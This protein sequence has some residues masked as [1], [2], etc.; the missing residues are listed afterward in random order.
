MKRS[1]HGL[2]GIATIHVPEVQGIASNQIRFVAIWTATVG[3]IK[4]VGNGTIAL[5]NVIDS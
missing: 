1:A 5:S 4:T 2:Q 3:E